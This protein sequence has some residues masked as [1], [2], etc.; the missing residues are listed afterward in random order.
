MRL[1]LQASVDVLNRSWTLPQRYS[2]EFL[3]LCVAG[4]IGSTYNIAVNVRKFIH[5]LLVVALCYGQLVASVHLV[6]HL[7]AEDCTGIISSAPE[8]C[9]TGSHHD[10]AGHS[11]QADA[12]HVHRLAGF[13]DTGSDRE[14]SNT[15][16]DC[17]IY[18]ALL[19]LDG[20]VPVQ[21]SKSSTLCIA[22]STGYKEIQFAR[23]APGALNIRAPPQH[24]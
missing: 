11:H 18:H 19:N 2:P 16:A 4:H 7:Q 20:G 17:A 12:H 3:S 5:S 23:Q 9:V 22:G 10:H 21:G 6:G 8:T 14:K 15:D 1:I 24:S 13:N